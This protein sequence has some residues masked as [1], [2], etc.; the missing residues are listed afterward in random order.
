[1]SR[2]VFVTGANSGIGLALC[3]QL[4]GKEYGCRVFLG[5]RSAEK[6]NAAVS[7][8]KKETPEAK[9]E[10]VEI[11]V[12]NDKSVV[13][14][15]ET[16]KKMLGGDKLYGVVNNAGVGLA[17]NSS[18][19]EILNVNFYGP[20]RVIDAFLPFVDKGGRVVNV[21]SGAGPMYVG[22]RAE[23]KKVDAVKLLTSW[24]TTYDQLNSYVQDES[25]KMSDCKED[26]FSA[27]GL[28]KS[29]LSVYTMVV[30]KA[31]K[32]AKSDILVSCLSPGFIATKLVAGF[33][34]SKTPAEGTVSIRKCLF[35]ELGGNGFFFGSDGLRSPL[36]KLRNP[37]EPEYKPSE[38]ELKEEQQHQ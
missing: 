2:I 27:Y 10:C 13:T 22:K 11:D 5:A 16:V 17:T 35:D 32:E 28:S 1:M 8:I 30:A 23:E 38:E 31:L 26:R 7:E 21:G 14:A 33:G 34:A 36:A 15:A 6:G 20:K 25:K 12:G 19:E 37:G 29:A 3:K 18:T 9:I 4:V 24:S